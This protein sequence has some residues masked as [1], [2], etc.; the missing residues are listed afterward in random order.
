MATQKGSNPLENWYE[1]SIGEPST[2]GEVY[3]YWM[4]VLGLVAGFLGIALVMFSDS[5]G[6]PIRG[7]GIALAGLGLILLLIGPIVRLPLK[8]SATMMSYVGAAIGLVAVGW[9][10]VAFNAGNWG[11]AFANSEPL[12]IG[13]Y[14]FGVLVIA[15]GSVLTPLVT[16]PREERKAAEARAGRAEAKRDAAREELER[17]E[18]QDREEQQAAE[19]RAGQAEATRDA[20]MREITRRE[21]GMATSE[22]EHQALVSELAQIEE[23]Q[24]Q[25]ELYTDSGG[26]HRWRLRHSND[27]IIADSAQGYTSRQG[28][29]QG[30]SAV[31][32]DAFGAA[33]MDLDKIETPESDGAEESEDPGTDEE[34]TQAAGD[35]AVETTF[36]TFEDAGGKH[37]W[38][39]RHG[40]DV[41][42][43]SGQGYASESSRDGAVESIRKYVQSADYLRLDPASFQLYRDEGGKH[44]WR[45]LHRNGGILADSGQGYSSR[46]KAKQGIESV[47]ANVAEGGNAEFDIYED[48][49]GEY[50]FRL[51]HGNGNII[52][53][54]APGHDSKSGAIEAADTLLEHAAAAHVLDIGSAAFEIYEDE[55]GKWRWRLRHRNGNIMAASTDDYAERSGAEASLNVVKQHAPEAETAAVTGSPDSAPK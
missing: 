28:A 38:R 1:D 3:G 26:K 53:A 5:A 22:A 47:Q 23:S 12:V 48:E 45:L 49:A 37:R 31:K 33:V 24:S 8:R 34:E 29:Q 43:S 17:Q 11:A 19:A 4:F 14:G 41:V 20:A 39:L 25:F 52:A 35:E 54:G 15:A 18:D 16:S 46:Q 40:D 36:E 30:L 10:V 44:R 6:E 55:A 21:E 7:A 13:L 32:R 51:V 9:F 27:N 2:S 50:R 42:A